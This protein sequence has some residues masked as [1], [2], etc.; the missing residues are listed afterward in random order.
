MRAAFFLILSFLFS[1]VTSFLSPFPASILIMAPFFSCHVYKY[2]S[3]LFLS[4]LYLPLL[5]NVTIEPRQAW[6]YKCYKE[7][8][9]HF[10][11]YSVIYISSMFCA[12]S[13]LGNSL[14]IYSYIY[15]VSVCVYVLCRSVVTLL[16]AS[17]RSFFL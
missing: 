15:T 16:S 2:F 17:S 11:Q 13:F 10:L 12:S 8:I 6:G 4:I 1:F 5:Y 7:M 14:Y 3:L 9:S